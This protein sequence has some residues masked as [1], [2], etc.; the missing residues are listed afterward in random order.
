M[1]QTQMCSILTHPARRLQLW[2]VQSD[3]GMT[4][5]AKGIIFQI[6]RQTQAFIFQHV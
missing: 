5:A 3:G 4:R 1:E 2:E 6:D